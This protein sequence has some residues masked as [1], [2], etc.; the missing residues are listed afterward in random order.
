MLE[1]IKQLPARVRDA[2][3][4]LPEKAQ[5]AAVRLFLARSAEADAANRQAAYRELP[6][7][8]R[9]LRYSAAERAEYEGDGWTIG[10]DDGWGRG[11]RD[12]S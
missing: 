5:E 8:E 9:V 4:K 11:P 12:S 7:Q 1:I 3:L 2:I 6:E 10:R